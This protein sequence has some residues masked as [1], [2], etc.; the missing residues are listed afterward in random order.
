MDNIETHHSTARRHLLHPKHD[1]LAECCGPEDLGHEAPAACLLGSEFPSTEQ[2]FI[3]L[4]EQRWEKAEGTE[5]CLQP[6]GIPGHTEHECLCSLRQDSRPWVRYAVRTTYEHLSQASLNCQKKAMGLL[7]LCESN[8]TPLQR[9]ALGWVCTGS[10]VHFS[11]VA[12]PCKGWSRKEG[13]ID[14]YVSTFQVRCDT[15]S[16]SQKRN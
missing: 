8:S 5:F 9:L 7:K 10:G 4:K 11:L 14:L 13:M 12:W 2:H 1:L 15:S 16:S 3:G 6:L